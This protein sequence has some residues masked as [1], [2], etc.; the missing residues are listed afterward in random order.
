[1]PVIS[2]LYLQRAS[3]LRSRKPDA[4]GRENT[5][6]EQEGG[7]VED[8]NYLLHSEGS[9]DSY[10]RGS[11]NTNSRSVSTDINDALNQIQHT[12]MTVDYSPRATEDPEGFDIMYSPDSSASGFTHD[13]FYRDLYSQS[14]LSIADAF[15]GNIKSKSSMDSPM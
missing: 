8:K 14:N 10:F 15:L 6:D 12:A 11:V 2:L 9:T 7:N 4:I 5:D 13:G 3:T 1:M